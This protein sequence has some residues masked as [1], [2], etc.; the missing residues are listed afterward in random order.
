MPSHVIPISCM[1]SG[2]M[3]SPYVERRSGLMKWLSKL[4]GGPCGGTSNGRRPQVMGGENM[5][6]HGPS[7]S[8]VRDLLS[9]YAF[10]SKTTQGSV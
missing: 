10:S 8:L 9:L 3:A 6:W 4:F 5:F 2:H 7:R 1:E